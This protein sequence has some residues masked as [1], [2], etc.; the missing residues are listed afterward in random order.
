LDCASV[1]GSNVSENRHSNYARS[2]HP[3]RDTWL[4]TL[5]CLMALRSFA[6]CLHHSR[7][8]S[9]S[10]QTRN[11]ITQVHVLQQ[12][13]LSYTRVAP[14]TTLI[15]TCCTSHYSHTHVLQQS[16]LS[17]T[18]VAAVTTLIHTCCS[19][20]YSHIHVLQ[21]SLL[22]YTR[23]A[24]VTTLIQ[25]E[26]YI[27]T[28]FCPDKQTLRGALYEANRENKLPNVRTRSSAGPIP[29]DRALS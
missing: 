18:R 23:V 21:Q 6:P 9:V 24:A 26:A 12:S 1:S 11:H 7:V 16:L 2:F 19:S 29:T 22:S 8:Q 13:L 15:H 14:V 10:R 4:F 3:P 27:S 20:H 25:S 17:Y 28:Q 5:P